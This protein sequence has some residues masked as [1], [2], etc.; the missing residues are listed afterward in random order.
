MPYTIDSLR[1]LTATELDLVGFSLDGKVK[2]RILRHSMR[3]VNQKV[4]SVT[5]ALLK[6]DVDGLDI[7]AFNDFEAELEEIES[8][9]QFYESTGFNKPETDQESLAKWLGVR[10]ALSE[11]GFKITAMSDMFKFIINKAADELILD[12]KDT[13]QTAKLSGLKES[14]VRD[15]LTRKALKNLASTKERCLEALH[16]INDIEPVA[17]TPTDFDKLMLAAI[18]SSKKSAII[19]SRTSQDAITNLILIKAMEDVA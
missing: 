7:D 9:N 4:H 16:L 5:A 1:E 15:L 11:S 18:E 13:S 10:L 19:R 6:S 14:A 17:E 8:R 3:I 2:G 12:D